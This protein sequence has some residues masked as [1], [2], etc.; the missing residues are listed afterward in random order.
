MSEKIY[1]FF[2][3]HSGDHD[4]A[5]ELYHLLKNEY[6]DYE[7]FLDLVDHPFD[8]TTDWDEAM[9]R[10]VDH[11]KCL[12]FITSDPAK[13]KTGNGNMAKEV[14]QFYDDFHNRERNGGA[15][16]GL[17]RDYFGIIF[18]EADFSSEPLS[19]HSALQNL[20]VNDC[21][22]VDDA[23]HRILTRIEA[24]LRD[25]SVF[26]RAELLDRVR[27]YRDLR[28]EQDRK[29][30]K[31][32]SDF[33]PA[34]VDPALCPNLK[35]L[36]E[37]L[38]ESEGWIDF[39]KLCEVIET[40][41]LFILGNE[42]GSG[43][44]SLMK[45]LFHHN[46]SLCEKDDYACDE[47]LFAHVPIFLDCKELIS[48]KKDLIFRFL[49][50]NLFGDSTAF[51]TDGLREEARLIARAFSYKKQRPEYLLLLDGLNEI[52]QSILNR[53]SE[54]LEE[55]I[56]SYP[57][58]RVVISGRERPKHA[59]LSDLPA[60]KLGELQPKRVNE[61]LSSRGIQI[62]KMTVKKRKNLQDVLSLPMFLK[63]F[64]DNFD[65]SKNEIRDASDLL[66]YQY[67]RQIERDRSI[68]N[69]SDRANAVMF[70]QHLLP[71]LAY[72]LV[73]TDQTESDFFFT[74]K[75]LNST[76]G[77]AKEL[78]EDEL[79]QSFYE[80]EF[81]DDE[82]YD[83]SDF[84]QSRILKLVNSAIKYFTGGCKML[85]QTGD[86]SDPDSVIFSF[87]HQ[88]YR[89]FFCAIYISQ[90]YRMAARHGLNDHLLSVLETSLDNRDMQ[91]YV[92]GLLRQYESVP[93]YN[94]K[95]RCW[96]YDCNRSSSLVKL[97]DLARK[98]N[99]SARIVSNLVILLYGVR[100]DDFS[101]LDFSGLDLTQSELRG[102]TFFHKDRNGI[103]PTSFS[104]AKLNYENLFFE[105]HNFKFIAAAI[106]P[107]KIA[108]LD[109]SGTLHFWNREMSDF[110]PIKT[111]E[112][113]STQIRKLLFSQDGEKLYAL[114]GHT[115]LELS[116]DEK[117]KT[118]CLFESVKFLRNI[119]LDESQ[120]LWFT[121][122]SD[123]Y[124]R[125]LVSDQT[126]IQNLAFRMLSTATAFDRSGEFILV[127]SILDHGGLQVYRKRDDHF[128]I[129]RFGYEKY[130]LDVLEKFGA[131]LRNSH[132]KL[133]HRFQVSYMDR[134]F[135]E[136]SDR[137]T[138]HDTMPNL[139]L[140]RI[141]NRIDEPLN[142]LLDARA[143]LEKLTKD[144]PT[145]KKLEELYFD[146]EDFCEKNYVEPSE[147]LLSELEAIASDYADKIRAAKRENTQLFRLGGMTVT[148]LD[149]HPTR[150]VFLLSLAGIQD[151]RKTIKSYSVIEFNPK[152]L[153]CVGICFG[154]NSFRIRAEY[155][156]DEIVVISDHN[157]SF[158]RNN[159]D[160]IRMLSIKNKQVNSFVHPENEDS[161]FVCASHFVYQFDRNGQITNAISSPFSGLDFNPVRD[162]RMNT[163]A[164]CE[165]GRKRSN[166]DKTTDTV[167]RNLITLDGYAY[168]AD[169]DD[170]E[171][172]PCVSDHY[173]IN[174]VGVNGHF[175]KPQKKAKSYIASFETT[176][177][178]LCGT[179]IVSYC[180]HK[181]V[182]EESVMYKAF[183]IGCD[184]RGINGDLSSPDNQKMLRFY[185]A[186]TDHANQ[187]YEAAPLS[188]KENREEKKYPPRRFV[189]SEN[190]E[191]SL[192]SYSEDL[193]LSVLRRW[194]PIKRSERDKVI[195]RDLKREN[196]LW[197]KISDASS[198]RDGDLGE[199][200]Y[201]VLEW[202]DRLSVATSEMLYTLLMKYFFK[203]KKSDLTLQDFS[204]KIML[205]KLCERYQLINS[206]RLS[207]SDRNQRRN[208]V[209]FSLSEQFGTPLLSHLAGHQVLPMPYV[210][211]P[212]VSQLLE[213][214]AVNQWLIRVIGKYP[215]WVHDYQ[216]SEIYSVKSHI[217]GISRMDLF[218][219]FKNQ[220]FFV[221]AFRR[222]TASNWKEFI[223]DKL[224]RIAHLSTYYRELTNFD[225][226]VE[227]SN[228][229]IAIILCEDFKHC[230]EIHHL[231]NGRYPDLGILYAYDRMNK[232]HGKFD[233]L[234]FV[235]GKPIG[236]YFTEL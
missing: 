186:I 200:D 135:R 1:D 24:S 67:Q 183:F 162:R 76:C 190:P 220:A 98:K 26:D 127:G 113:V 141:R 117:L 102:Y 112:G 96:N 123:P 115:V 23:K 154:Q 168:T 209:C 177:F 11:S 225:T 73:C 184:F 218:M 212:F 130:L 195:L 18:S 118:K 132:E 192:Y 70:L 149:Y 121:Y 182:S 169:A 80:K 150:D 52:P 49:L 108:T 144:H 138:E 33:S 140:Q 68:T 189:P 210:K 95:E 211:E 71:Y 83:R 9:L 221:E 202:I 16:K 5:L 153:E 72:T 229:P 37:S 13:L 28:V 214:L 47:D 156:G 44:T 235:D 180:D 110:S 137:K 191:P 61:Y 142:R 107:D 136:F 19:R 176:D 77:A 159:G 59:H 79:Y 160:M 55:F 51:K 101:G 6:Q 63:L 109:A 226:R 42:G 158:Y 170:L 155:H 166:P 36:D 103:H 231:I 82:L 40:R 105:N 74:K 194:E 148:N 193:K 126:S 94:V 46:L 163:I 120:N 174:V 171:R 232:A 203:D 145:Y 161:F 89:D 201:F 133:A 8:G 216:I 181:M 97:L 178:R 93:V 38:V 111:Y 2:I 175:P 31:G 122:A 85:N 32:D 104:G 164:F 66:I 185:G 65:P 134:L 213:K 10:F 198:V 151:D 187:V 57:N 165:P 223:T 78:F 236:I 129:I 75:E 4:L 81:Y 87:V 157:V 64:S 56:D 116:I 128:E 50:K 21:K 228:C 208:A 230:E 48:D 167:E 196:D 224:D 22:T 139:I 90:A 15:D 84:S 100:H 146:A 143:R 53:F 54:E 204:T 219:R 7:I 39:E 58:V 60:F 30:G 222:Y 92:S 152:T 17:Y 99:F 35:C 179:D 215:D 114:T 69:P 234:Q 27:N 124:E 14:K 45:Q 197:D 41:N 147:E 227:L 188:P 3:S 88:N 91:R 199:M 86:D 29:N 131:C 233:A 172:I 217:K 12:I 173:D 25:Q 43:K 207:S 119:G 206:Y 106:H 125:Y 205:E 62:Y 34:S 20:V